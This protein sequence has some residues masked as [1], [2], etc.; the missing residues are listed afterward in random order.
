MKRLCKEDREW[1]KGIC[2]SYSSDIITY[3]EQGQMCWEDVQ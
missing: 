3:I 1:I 2:G